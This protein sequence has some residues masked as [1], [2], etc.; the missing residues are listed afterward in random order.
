MARRIVL[1][2]L[3]AEFTSPTGHVVAAAVSLDPSATMWAR[4]GRFFQQ[5]AGQ[6]VHSVKRPFLASD[7]DGRKRPSQMN[8]PSSSN[9]RSSASGK[10]HSFSYCCGRRRRGRDDGLYLFFFVSSVWF[11]SL[12]QPRI[13]LCQHRIGMDHGRPTR[14]AQA[15]QLDKSASSYASPTREILP[16]QH[17]L[18]STRVD[19]S[20][21]LVTRCRHWVWR[22][23]SGTQ[24]CSVVQ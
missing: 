15:E 22:R 8:G 6:F 2:A 12:C 24:T 19:L 7:N 1:A 21:G 11:P 14:P 5:T 13:S 9:S 20:T 17:G 23:T 4:F 16:K 10:R 3:I 18:V